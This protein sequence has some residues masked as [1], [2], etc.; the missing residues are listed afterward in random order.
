LLFF[1]IGV[2]VGQ[3]IFVA[4]VLSLIWLLRQVASLLLEVTLVKR[5]F[6]R[7]D[8]TIAYGIGGIAAYWLIERTTAF[9]A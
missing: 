6:D 5:A 4:T 2:E 8:V 7:L 3:L 9:F 1:N